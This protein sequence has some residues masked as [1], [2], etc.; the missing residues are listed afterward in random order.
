MIRSTRSDGLNRR[1]LSYRVQRLQAY[2]NTCVWETQLLRFPHCAPTTA[3][4]ACTRLENTNLVRPVDNRPKNQRIRTITRSHLR[5]EVLAF[6]PSWSPPVPTLS[7]SVSAMPSAA[8]G[9]L[10]C[11]CGGRAVPSALSVKGASDRVPERLLP[12]SDRLSTRTSD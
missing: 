6:G 8:L 2:L 5:A 10:C 1:K 4:T 7:W 12:A 11:F 3:T 9:I